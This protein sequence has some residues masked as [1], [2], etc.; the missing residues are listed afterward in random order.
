VN[1]YEAG[2]VEQR[3]GT[4]IAELAR[5]LR[6]VIVTRGAEGATL[7]TDGT[8]QAIAPVSAEAVVDPTGCGDA[9]RAG[10]LYALT[11]GWGWADA[12]KLANVMGAIKIAS[13][14]PQNHAPS[15]SEISKRLQ[16]AYGLELPPLA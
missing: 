2:V 8:E 10:L 3:T 12:C 13:R 15:R 5:G 16:Q 9:H 4:G 11:I 7:W 6:A 1:D 14:G